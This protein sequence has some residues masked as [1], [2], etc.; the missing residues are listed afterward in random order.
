MG[1][2][3]GARRR[4]LNLSKPAPV[5]LTFDD[6]PDPVWTRRVLDALRRAETRA[7]FFVVAPAARREPALISEM[8]D[9]GHRVELHC[10]EHVR[11]ADRTREEIETDT[12]A[13][14]TD[15]H[16]LGVRPRLWRP[17]WGIVAP[18][19]PA[20]A[21]SF[22][23]DLALWTIEPHDWRG[24]SAGEMLAGIETR[25]ESGSV[26]LLHDGLGPGALRIGC[27][28]TV[29]LIPAL[30]ESIR[31]RGF[32]PVPM[33]EAAIAAGSTTERAPA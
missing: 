25:I 6:G 2:Y 32:E 29:A 8:L 5:H 12:E 23:L 20:I 16:A 17:P 14:L 27:E 15:L 26:V 18:W 4:T 7:T 28:E 21:K 10:A 24:D 9:A 31:A 19:T 22:G 30:V 1:L 33:T 13:A 11:H 3:T